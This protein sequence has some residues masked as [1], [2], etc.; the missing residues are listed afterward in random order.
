MCEVQ[1]P[2]LE[3]DAFYGYWVMQGGDPISDAGSK[4]L[5]SMAIGAMLENEYEGYQDARMYMGIAT[6]FDAIVELG[7]LRRFID[8]AR[9]NRETLAEE[10]SDPALRGYYKA[11]QH[12]CSNQGLVESLSTACSCLDDTRAHQSHT[13]DTCLQLQQ[14]IMRCSRCLQARYCSQ[15][16]QRRDWKHHKRYCNKFLNAQTQLE[17]MP[18]EEDSA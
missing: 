13:C 2:G 6:K 14:R 12:I 15:A 10:G 7:G 16:C 5:R 4:M 11:L 9:Y 17:R 8:T 3:Y 18:P 1:E